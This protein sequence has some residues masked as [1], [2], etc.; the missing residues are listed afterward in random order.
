MTGFLLPP[1][2]ITSIEEYLA[3]EHGGRGVAAVRELGPS[4]VVEIITESGLRGRGGGGFPTGRKW[5]SIAS[6]PGTRYVVANGAEGEPGTFKD[7]ALLRNDPWAV[8]EGAVVAATAVGAAEVYLCIKSTF[9]EEIENLTRAVKEF[10]RAGICADCTVNI[11]AGPDEYLFGEE[12]A[13]LEVI[14]GKP[15][16][17]RRFPPYIHGLFASSPQGGWEAAPHGSGPRGD[18][19][20]PTLVNNLETLANV[21]HILARGVERFRV[22]GTAE[23]P[24]TIIATVVGDVIAPDV[25]EVELGTP[26]RAVIDAVGSGV[27]PGRSVKAVFSGVANPVVTADHLDIPLS[28][29]G[30]A[31]IGSG[32]GA[33]G[34]IVFDD[35]ACMVAAVAAMSRF[36]AIESCGQCPPC[37]LGSEAI[38]GHLNAI[39]AG[40]G[41]DADIAAIGGW[42]QRVTDGNRCYLAV[43]EQQLVASVLRAFPEEFAAHIEQGRCPRPGGRPFAKLVDLRD[44]RATYDQTYHRKRPDWTYDP[45]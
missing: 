28:Y 8:V 22:T 33:A 31:A 7:R 25:G 44:G 27:A 41:T 15:P 37:K 14:E 40:T 2:P 13:M 39:E 36:L 4:A 17:P 26:L 12:K 42:L 18:D 1:E 30:F 19:P 21:P 45:A 34:F 35:T 11:V 29:E 9:T 3:T 6:Q 5:A 24:G 32:M 38:T 10:Q 43:E 16:L 20:N 23:S